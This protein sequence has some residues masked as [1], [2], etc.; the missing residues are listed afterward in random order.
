MR[1]LGP[2]RCLEQFVDGEPANSRLGLEDSQVA[3]EVQEAERPRQREERKAVLRSE[4]AVWI[5]GS[6]S[7]SLSARMSGRRQVTV[8]MVGPRGGVYGPCVLDWRRALEFEAKLEAAAHASLGSSNPVEI[9]KNPFI[10]FVFDA[11]GN[12]VRVEVIGQGRIIVSADDPRRP[13]RYSCS[14]T[15]QQALN[16]ARDV[17]LLAELGD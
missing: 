5:N 12:M 8:A 10:E 2:T 15:A 1:F 4:P 7:W 11:S 3:R 16:L 9:L 6:G 17:R 14:L 13:N